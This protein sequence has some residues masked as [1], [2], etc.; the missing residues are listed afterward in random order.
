VPWYSIN[1]NVDIRVDG[2]G[3]EVLLELERTD[4]AGP[5]QAQRRDALRILV[6]AIDTLEQESRWLEANYGERYQESEYWGEAGVGDEPTWQQIED[7]LKRSAGHGFTLWASFPDIGVE[8]EIAAS[9]GLGEPRREREEIPADHSRRPRRVGAR[10][11]QVLEVLRRVRSGSPS[12]L[13]KVRVARL[14]AV[15]AVAKARNVSPGTISDKAQRQLKRRSET[16]RYG[17]PAFDRDVCAWLS[18]GSN[19]LR[20]RM[21]DCAGSGTKVQDRAA[22]NRFF[23]EKGC[24][25]RLGSVDESLYTRLLQAKNVVL[26]GVPGT[27]KTFAYKEL[28]EGWNRSGIPGLPPL[29]SHKAVTFHPATTYE[30][31]VEGI[32]PRAQVAQTTPRADGHC[33]AGD[34]KGIDLFWTPV[35]ADGSGWGVEDGFFLR[36]CSRAAADPQRAHL[37]LLDEINRANVPKVLGDLLTTLERSKRAIWSAEGW[38]INNSGC[39]TLPVSK[40]RFFVPENVYVLATMNSSDRSVTPLDTALRR[41]FAFYRLEPMSRKKLQRALGKDINPDSVGKD[42]QWSRTLF[43]WEQTKEA[44]QATLGPDGALG[45]S[46]LFDIAGDLERLGLPLLDDGT[47]QSIEVRRSGVFDAVWRDAI[48]PQVIA[49]IRAAGMEDQLLAPGEESERAAAVQL[50]D[51]LARVDLQIDLVGEGFLRG[52]SVGRCQGP[53]GPAELEA[54]PEDSGE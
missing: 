12:S 2:G 33:V 37:V 42:D 48:A 7:C 18:E 10:T 17:M 47:D 41:R 53:H 35:G 54:Q 26:E 32:R 9:L 34:D 36:A 30:D 16:D 46:Y 1:Q 45:H 52:P 6:E 40:R 15:A 38:E 39:V 29:G 8:E 19:Q 21:L 23:G 28:I 3:D 20:D 27:G 50:R 24:Q 51:A 11:G 13:E 4:E 5:T 25:P 14:D 31:F 49:S 22:I 43:A 44:L